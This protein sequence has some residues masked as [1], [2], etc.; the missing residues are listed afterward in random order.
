M[1]HQNHPGQ[2]LRAHLHRDAGIPIEAPQSFPVRPDTETWLMVEYR[3]DVVRQNGAKLPA[4][5]PGPIPRRT[6][7]PNPQRHRGDQC[8]PCRP[9]LEELRG[10]HAGLNGY[11]FLKRYTRISEAAIA[12]RDTSQSN[13][14]ESDAHFART[15]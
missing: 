6:K 10:A 7:S 13:S 5:Y 8:G 1:H 3:R 4:P 15:A 2:S 11:I 14:E 9:S 12:A